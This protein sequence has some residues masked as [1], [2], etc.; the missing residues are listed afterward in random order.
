MSF[1]TAL[2]AG[3]LGGLAAAAINIIVFFVGN[4]PDDVLTP[5]DQPITVGAVI[6]ASVVGVA[7]GSV[8]LYFLRDR[9]RV[10]QIVV[11]AVTLL[12]FFQ[13]LGIEGAPG[14]MVATLFLMHLVAGEVAAFLVPRLAGA[15]DGWLLGARST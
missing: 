3:L 15:T 10:Y 4:V 7:L 12:S 1:G 13:P 5:M 2:R 6:F 9:V 8:V 14:S 11:G